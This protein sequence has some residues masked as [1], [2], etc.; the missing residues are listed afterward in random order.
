[1]RGRRTGLRSARAAFSLR[2]ALPCSVAASVLE[3]RVRGGSLEPVLSLS[4]G[5]CHDDRMTAVSWRQSVPNPKRGIVEEVV[6]DRGYGSGSEIRPAGRQA[7]ALQPSRTV[8][9]SQS[10]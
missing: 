6:R 3:P 4:A 9:V 2:E 10:V 7:V 1:M 5:R 8:G